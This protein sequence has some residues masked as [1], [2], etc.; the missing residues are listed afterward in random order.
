MKKILIIGL[1]LAL[2]LSMACEKTKLTKEQKALV[3]QQ[4]SAVRFAGYKNTALWQGSPAE[5]DEYLR[6][7]KFWD[8]KV[9][10]YKF[11]PL[12]EARVEK[13]GDGFKGKFELGGV[14]LNARFVLVFYKPG[15]DIWYLVNLENRL[16]VVLRF[17]LKEA[18]KHTKV[19]VTGNGETSSA[20]GELL[21]VI[22]L[23]EMLAK[24]IDGE[25]VKGQAHFDSSVNI[26]EALGNGELGAFY[27]SLL[28]QY[29]GSIWINSSLKKV[30]DYLVKPECWELFKTKYGIELSNCFIKGEPGPCPVKVSFMGGNFEFNTFTADYKFTDHMT[31]YGVLGQLICR[32]Q[33]A[34]KAENGGTRL[35]LTFATEL[36]PTVSS[37]AGD[38][39]MAIMQ[40]PKFMEQLLVN[41]KTAVEGA[42]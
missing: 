42:G 37:D 17:N 8:M 4:T 16:F 28:Q 11:K 22:N 6:N 15:Q 29:Q 2:T 5:V 26:E 14:A 3:E 36:P 34:T 24:L 32:F 20:L 41:T 7:P 39:F 35:Y 1:G 38:T 12:S 10:I 40:L 13:L 30:N 23:P 19:T 33:I 18:Q 9:G 21:E 31:S 25:V 27:D